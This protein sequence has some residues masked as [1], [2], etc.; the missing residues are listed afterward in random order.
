MNKISVLRISENYC[1]FAALLAPYRVPK[2]L[3]RLY[4]KLEWRVNTTSKT[5]YLTFDDG[6]HPEITRWVLQFLDSRKIKATFFCVGENVVKFPGVLQE[7]LMA[8]HSVGNHSHRH[9]KGW[10]TPV[11]KYVA[12]VNE[13]KGHIPANLFR[14]PYGRIKRQQAALLQAAGYKIIMWSLLSCDYLPNLN[15]ENAKKN[16]LKLCRPGDIVVF[17]DSVKAYANLQ[18][19]LPEFVDAMMQLGYNFE[20]L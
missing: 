11:K 17:H 14:P 2:L 15:R 1:Q 18:E 8:G 19:I 7:I 6:P 12:D 20:P 5:I 3:I 4:P 9:L 10:N 16:L 13:A